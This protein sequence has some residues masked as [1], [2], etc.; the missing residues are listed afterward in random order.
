MQETYS[1]RA[2]MPYDRQSWHGADTITYGYADSRGWGDLLTSYDGRSF[3]TMRS[4]N[5]LSDGEWTHT[6]RRA[7]S[8]RA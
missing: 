3:S 5:L 8:W 4:G 1:A 2:N 7:A 6:G